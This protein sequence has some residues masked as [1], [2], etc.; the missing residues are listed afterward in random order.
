[1]SAESTES[2]VIQS[3]VTRIVQVRAFP[4]PKICSS[5]KGALDNPNDS[6]ENC[7]AD[8]VSDVHPDNA[9]KA[10]ERPEYWV[11]SAAPNVPG[12]IRPTP[13]SIKKVEH[14]L[15]TVSTL[16]PRRNKGNKKKWDWL[17][18]YVFTR[19]YMLLD[20][21]FHL[22]KYRGRIVSSCVRTL[23][24]KSNYSRQI[25][26]FREIY[27]FDRMREACARKSLGSALPT[28]WVSI[29]QIGNQ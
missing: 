21:E 10:S 5:W 22:E 23:V 24:H 29:R 19:F 26:I 17:G 15:M 13:R 27:Q 3:K 4:N 20:R 8:N 16:K 14:W 7:M 12:L 6:E 18:Q 2:T 11:V 1:M 25:V 9:I 28:G